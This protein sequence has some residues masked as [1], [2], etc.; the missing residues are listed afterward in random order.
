MYCLSQVYQAHLRDVRCLD[1]NAGLL[2]TGGNDKRCLMFEY[3]EGKCTPLTSSD[4]M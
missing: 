1:Y 3:K 2:V 4:I